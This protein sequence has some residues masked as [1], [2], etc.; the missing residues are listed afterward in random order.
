VWENDNAKVDSGKSENWITA[1][2]VGGVVKETTMAS[3][4]GL[5]EFSF[6]FCRQSGVKCQK[7]GAR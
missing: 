7:R 3:F 4:G 6:P 2:L 5:M 1:G